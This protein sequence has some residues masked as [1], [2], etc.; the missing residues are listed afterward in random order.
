MILLQG[1]YCS[2]KLLSF[3][4]QGGG[5]AFPYDQYA[6]NKQPAIRDTRR[7]CTQRRQHPQRRPGR[8]S[9]VHT[10]RRPDYDYV[11]KAV[12]R[13]RLAAFV[14]HFLADVLSRTTIIT[15]FLW[16]F[17]FLLRHSCPTATDFARGTGGYYPIRR[18]DTSSK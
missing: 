9:L 1:K 18:V 7:A 14:A 16:G 10:L 12:P 17:R 8:L 2:R 6:A 5:L 15:Q 4:E 13:T 3:S 11:L